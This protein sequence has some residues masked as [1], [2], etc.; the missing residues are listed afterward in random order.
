MPT[1]SKPPVQTITRTSPAGHGAP[2]RRN[3]LYFLEMI[4]PDFTLKWIVVSWEVG[5]PEFLPR[6]DLTHQTSP[7]TTNRSKSLP[8]DPI[9]LLRWL[10]AHWNTHQ[11]PEITFPNELWKERIVS[12]S[13]P[14]AQ[15]RYWLRHFHKCRG[16]AELDF[17]GSTSIS[18]AVRNSGGLETSV[19]A[20]LLSNRLDDLYEDGDLRTCVK[21]GG[22]LLCFP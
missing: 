6:S 14:F 8:T 4:H 15:N 1:D 10:D 20:H 19:P 5:Y 17:C 13:C 2:R 7:T 22:S 21:G 3:I 16:H 11:T 12:K 18:N 9:Q